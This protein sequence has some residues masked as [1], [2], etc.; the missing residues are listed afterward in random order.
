GKPSTP[1]LN[2]AAIPLLPMNDYYL[3]NGQNQVGPYTGEQIAE[4]REKG[5]L[6]DSDHLW[7][8]GMAE[9]DTIGAALAP[10]G[11]LGHLA[12]V[13]EAGDKSGPQPQRKPPE[14][15]AGGHS[16]VLVQNTPF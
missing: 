9:W 7:R 2:T 15:P 1:I 11:E 13:A 16:L 10:G 14:L 4:M 6:G 8:E 12:A 5:I 3:L